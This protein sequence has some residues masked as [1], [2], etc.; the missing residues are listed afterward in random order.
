MAPLF[1]KRIVMKIDYSKYIIS[2]FITIGIFLVFF[3][4]SEYW[5]E[6]KLGNLENIQQSI[7]IDLL[8]TE[9]QFLLKEVSCSDESNTAVAKQITELG[10][11]LT[12]AESE[13][14]DDNQQVQFLKKY[15]SLL[16]IKDYLLGKNIQDRCGYKKRPI[17]MIY[18]Y[19]SK[20]K[21]KDCE[22]LADTLSKLRDKY[23]ELKVYT[24]DYDIDLGP[25]NTLKDIYKMQPKFPL[26]VIE[27]KTYYG[28]QDF[29]TIEKLLPNKLKDN[30]TKN[31]ST[32][33]SK[34]I[35]STTTGQSKSS[36][37]SNIFNNDDKDNSID[38]KSST[39]TNVTVT[40]K[41]KAN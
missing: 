38:I 4:L 27:D 8:S 16:E 24:F 31:E 17:Y 12:F 23:P 37:F 29:D 2:L 36:I 14:G 41:V 39:T 5:T 9:T 25:V 10:D 21:C 7:S 26:L 13:L 18:M 30:I 15:Y 20:E 19:S 32:K 3:L 34:T 40:N 6:K 22:V 33:K 28:L 35:N 11:K 1:E